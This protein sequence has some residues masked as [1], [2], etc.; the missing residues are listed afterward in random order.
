MIAH[1]KLDRVRAIHGR[2]EE[3]ALER[4]HRERYDIVTA[5][6]VAALPTL[7][8]YTLPFVVVGG[9]C[10]AMKGGTAEEEARDASRAIHQ[11]GG[12]LEAITPVTLPGRPD[13]RALI[14]IRK[15]AHT[16]PKY[17][18]QAGAPRNNPL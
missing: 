14:L 4:I 3:L 18:R 10:I 16:P 1:L 6:A 9:I 5:R 12:K 17:P 15:I 2:S 13:K 7:V 11:L 8:E